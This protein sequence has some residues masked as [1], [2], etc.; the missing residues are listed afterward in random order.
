MTSW[1]LKR[2]GGLLKVCPLTFDCAVGDGLDT[3][4][5]RGCVDLPAGCHPSP[6]SSEGLVDFG[7]WARLEF[8]RPCVIFMSNT[9]GLI[10]ALLDGSLVRPGIT[11]VSSDE[12]R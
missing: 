11:N 12:R 9:S 10:L 8:K 2:G 5:L 1:P 7:G 4:L 6:L 3:A